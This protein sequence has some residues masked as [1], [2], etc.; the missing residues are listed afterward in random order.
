[1]VAPGEPAVCRAKSRPTFELDCLK[2]LECNL[3]H[4]M[5]KGITRSYDFSATVAQSQLGL[6][7][8]NTITD[9]NGSQK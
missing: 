1:M 9:Y 6:Y 8:G 2:D 5:T 7:D 3:Q 4:P